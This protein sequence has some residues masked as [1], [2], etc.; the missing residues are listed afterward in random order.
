VPPKKN[1]APPLDL[2]NNYE[3]CTNAIVGSPI[4]SNKKFENK[5]HSL[6]YTISTAITSNKKHRSS[7]EKLNNADLVHGDIQS[8]LGNRSSAKDLMKG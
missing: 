7:K 2:L 4:R 3:L 6:G 8:V 5:R 1:A